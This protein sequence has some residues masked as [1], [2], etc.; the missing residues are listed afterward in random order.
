M[1]NIFIAD[2]RLFDGAGEGAGTAASGE[3]NAPAVAAQ[4]E[5]PQKV[6]Y[7][8]QPESEPAAQQSTEGAKQSDEDRRKAFRELINSPEYKDLYTEE[9]QKVINK[10]FKETKALEEKVAALERE[11]GKLKPVIDASYRRY[12]VADGDADALVKAV[13]ADNSIYEQ[14]AYEAGMSVEQYAARERLLKDNARITAERD[15]LLQQQQVDS[16]VKQWMAD[17]ESVKQHYPDFDLE[18]ALGD[19]QF[20]S[21]LQAGV[22]MEHAYRVVN[23]DAIVAQNNRQTAALTEKAVVDSVRAKGARPAENG[24]APRSAFVV[25]DDVT[26][27]NKQDRAAIAQKAM[28]GERISF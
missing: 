2:L 8:K 25:K 4:E 20:V 15:K 12:N 24:V 13:E 27:L 9:T 28:R 11:N 23:L 6:V 17:A 16:Q 10:R 26:K 21:L 14:A 3:G 5:K 18:T 22:P 1:Q 7:G 19:K